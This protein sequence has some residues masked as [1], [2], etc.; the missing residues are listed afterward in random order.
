[1]TERSHVLAVD[2]H[3]D[4]PI[5]TVFRAWTDPESP[6]GW[7]GP[8]GFTLE[9]YDSD[10]R[11]GGRWRIGMRSADGDLMVSRGTYRVI[12]APTGLVMTHGW[13]NA[14]RRTGPETLVTVTFKKHGGG[15]AMSFEQTGFVSA[16]DRDGHAAGWG[17]AFDAL[18]VALRE[19]GA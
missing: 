4:A 16:S 6:V 2:R 9:S 10:L 11:P 14:G 19:R 13:G 7:W 15:T 18:S 5:V 3:F 8:K 17:E 1:M 12:T